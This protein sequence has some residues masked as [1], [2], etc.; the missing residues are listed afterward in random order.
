MI[1]PQ[2]SKDWVPT[3]LTVVLYF[4]AALAIFVGF[5]SV[6]GMNSFAHTLEDGR[7]LGV[8][9]WAF[10]VM[11][12]ALVIPQVRGNYLLLIV[13]LAWTAFHLAGSLF[14]FL[15]KGDTAFIPPVI[16]ESV[17]LIAYGFFFGV[18]SRR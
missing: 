17:L 4:Q 3:A 15:V 10:A 1:Q 8:G 5:A 16:I 11:L 12:V 7:R 14:E 9:F 6:L 2:P 18:L 13:P